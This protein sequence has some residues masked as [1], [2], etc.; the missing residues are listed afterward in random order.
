VVRVATAILTNPIQ[1]NI[2][3]TDQLVANKAGGVAY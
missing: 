2:G 3:D 1:V